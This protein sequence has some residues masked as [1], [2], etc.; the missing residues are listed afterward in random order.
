MNGFDA[1]ITGDRTNQVSPMRDMAERLFE[2]ERKS[3]A[4]D[5]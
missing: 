2:D 5:G 4:T 1:W 3:V